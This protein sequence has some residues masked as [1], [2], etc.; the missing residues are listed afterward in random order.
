MHYSHMWPWMHCYPYPYPM[1]LP[2]PTY[3][4]ELAENREKSNFNNE[5]IETVIP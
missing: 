3:P 2:V 5:K 4:M 1:P